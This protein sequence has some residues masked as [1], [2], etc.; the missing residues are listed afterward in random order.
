MIYDDLSVHDTPLYVCVR[1]MDTCT[2]NAV[3]IFCHTPIVDLYL[4]G[5][6]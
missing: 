2:L 5:Q 4:L 3:N 6:M 1:H